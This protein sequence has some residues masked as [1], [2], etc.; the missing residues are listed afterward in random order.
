LAIINI[1]HQCMYQA[2]NSTMQCIQR[3]ILLEHGCPTE[4]F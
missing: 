2:A 1:K 4:P 3:Q